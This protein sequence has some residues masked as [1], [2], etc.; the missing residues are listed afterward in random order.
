MK[1]K[2]KYTIY[3][4]LYLILA[5]ICVS[6]IDSTFNLF[7]TKPDIYSFGFLVFVCFCWWQSI[8]GMCRNILKIETEKLRE[9][10][11]HAGKRED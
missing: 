7:A 4:V 1:T 8:S 6:F 2:T 9:E 3:S 5:I 11:E 10:I